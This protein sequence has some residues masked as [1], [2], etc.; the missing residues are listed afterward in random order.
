MATI[1]IVVV[2]LSLYL[3]FRHYQFLRHYFQTIRSHD[4]D[5]NYKLALQQIRL[6]TK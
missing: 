3:I 6:L 5:R 1:A 4:Q 2:H